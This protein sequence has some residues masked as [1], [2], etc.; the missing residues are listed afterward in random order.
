MKL[1]KVRLADGKVRVALVEDTGVLLLDM[2]QVSGVRLLSDIL[3]APDPVGLARFLVDPKAGP[4]KTGEVTFLAPIDR[5]EVWAGG[6]DLQAQPDRPHGRV[7]SGASHYDKVYTAPRPEIFFKATPHRV[8]G[9]G[10][11]VRVRA[12]SKLVGPRTRVHARS[13]PGRCRSSVTR[14]ATICRPAISRERTRSICRR[15]RST[16]SV[17]RSGRVSC[18]LMDRCTKTPSQLTCRS[19]ATRRKSSGARHRSAR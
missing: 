4:I 9:P 5:Q 1:A 10:E 12:D 3:H 15:R 14:S 13:Q 18:W 17:A 11:P 2:E 7:G 16:T 19:S 6:C 8:S